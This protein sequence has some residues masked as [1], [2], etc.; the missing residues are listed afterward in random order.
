MRHILVIVILLTHILCNVYYGPFLTMGGEDNSGGFEAQIRYGRALSNNI[1]GYMITAVDSY[2]DILAIGSC[3]DLYILNMSTGLF[4]ANYTLGGIIL[5]LR[6]INIDSDPRMELLVGVGSPFFIRSGQEGATYYSTYRISNIYNEGRCLH[7]LDDDFSLRYSLHYS[8]NPVDFARVSNYLVVC[9]ME[10]SIYF[11]DIQDLALVRELEVEAGE[12]LVFYSMNILHRAFPDGTSYIVSVSGIHYLH[13]TASILYTESRM[14]FSVT[15]TKT[16]V[17]MLSDGL[18]V[19]DS[20]IIRDSGYGLLYGY[21]FDT[22]ALNDTIYLASERTVFKISYNQTSHL[23]HVGCL[24]DVYLRYLYLPWAYPYPVRMDL[25]S[26]GIYEIVYPGDNITVMDIDAKNI[27]RFPSPTIFYLYPIDNNTIVGLGDRK[28]YILGIHGDNIDIREVA[29]LGKYFDCWTFITLYF[30]LMIPFLHRILTSRPSDGDKTYIVI[31]SIHSVGFTFIRDGE[32]YGSVANITDRIISLKCIGFGMINEGTI[33]PM[34]I[35][36]HGS[37]WIKSSSLWGTHYVLAPN[38]SI[39]PINMENPLLVFPYND[40]LFTYRDGLVVIYDLVRGIETEVANISEILRGEGYG[41]FQY[42][43]GPCGAWLDMDGDN[44]RDI[45]ACVLLFNESG[46]FSIMVVLVNASLSGFRYEIVNMSSIPGPWL[47][48][49]VLRLENGLLVSFIGMWDGLVLNITRDLNIAIYSIYKSTGD[50]DLILSEEYGGALALVDLQDYSSMEKIEPLH[51]KSILVYTPTNTSF[52]SMGGPVDI[53]KYDNTVVFA[54]EETIYVLREGEARPILNIAGW[55]MKTFDINGNQC[56]IALEGGELLVA[57][58]S[59]G[60]ILGTYIVPRDIAFIR[61]WNNTVILFADRED[62]VVI[63]TLKSERECVLRNENLLYAFKTPQ[64]VLVMTDRDYYI[65][66]V[67]Y[68]STE[69][70]TT[71]EENIKIFILRLNTSAYMIL[72]IL[73]IIIITIFVI[74]EKKRARRKQSRPLRTSLG[75]R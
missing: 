42:I 72:A 67:R 3:R 38:G 65:V 2:G 35:D 34:I 27:T 51:V 50:I 46:L 16:V 20:L 8:G 55:G 64:G 52:Y 40:T 1:S 11:Y 14:L 25:D 63:G 69:T 47:A 26:D 75:H 60:R 48:T 36:T 66:Q 39:N 10:G 12:Q 73:A 71:G 24:S 30:Y 70:S 31:I 4:L 53:N 62:S 17:L 15:R 21:V 45:L 61:I 13:Y 28:L 37:Y 54:T 18:E 22:I 7:I 32:I 41:G 49:S 19:K 68:V 59:V 57:D 43:R 33:Y 56:Y 74:I 44:I 29:H 5:R 9:T 23:W 58:I 6:F